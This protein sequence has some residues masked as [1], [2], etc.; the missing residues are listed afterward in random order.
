MYKISIILPTFNVEKYIKRCFD[1]LLS[2]TIGFSNLEVIFVDDCSTDDSAKIIDEYA[3]TYDNVISIHLSENSGAAGKPRNEGIRHAT[4]D[5]LLFLDPDDFLM[6]NACEVLYAKINESHV[7]IV[8]GGYV[9]EDWVAH[10]RSILKTEETLI[11]N[12]KSNLSIYFNPPGLASKLFRKDL[13]LKNNIEFPEKIP[14]QDL[15]FLTEAYLNAKL[16]LSLN[17]FVVHRYCIRDEE[18]NKSITQNITKEYFYN[19]LK[20]YNLT[21]DLLE[22]FEVDYLLRKL[23]FTKNHFNFLR[24][25]LKQL[26]VSDEELQEIFDSELFRNIKNQEFVKQ[27]DELNNFFNELVN[28]REKVEGKTLQEICRRTKRDFILS[29]NFISEKKYK[30]YE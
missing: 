15:V 22:K 6:E 4:A 21:L 9:K 23:Y 25:Q 16:I 13:I 8:V 11:E 17:N 10:W 18:N 12:P 1:S 30:Y 2:Q 3:N 19:L 29:D 24:V 28:D 26:E 14:A 7:D 20:A 5:Y 27:D